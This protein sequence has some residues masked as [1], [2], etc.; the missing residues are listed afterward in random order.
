MI[1]RPGISLSHPSGKSN[2]YFFLTKTS[3]FIKDSIKTT[4]SNPIWKKRR[5]KSFYF[6]LFSDIQGPHHLLAKGRVLGDGHE[7][8]FAVF[9]FAPTMVVREGYIAFIG[10]NFFIFISLLFT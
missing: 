6:Q 3:D 10:P 4:G 7:I 2:F 1:K 9:T 5:S 8:G